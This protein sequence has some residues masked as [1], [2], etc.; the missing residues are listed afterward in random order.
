[1]AAPDMPIL[2]LSSPAVSGDPAVSATMTCSSARKSLAVTSWRP[3][4]Y[5]P[6]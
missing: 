5:L 2:V 6:I 4:K 3:A 1:M